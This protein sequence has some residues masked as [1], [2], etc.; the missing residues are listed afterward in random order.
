MRRDFLN[1]L[2]TV[3][4]FFETNWLVWEDTATQYLKE[5]KVRKQN[6]HNAAKKKYG[7]CLEWTTYLRH[8]TRVEW[9]HHQNSER[10]GGHQEDAA[11]RNSSL[12]GNLIE[13]MLLEGV[14]PVIA[15]DLE[16]FQK[17][18][19][20]TYLNNPQQKS[21]KETFTMDGDKNCGNWRRRRKTRWVTSSER[22]YSPDT[23]SSD[24]YEV[25]HDVGEVKAEL[26][27]LP[28]LTSTP[29]TEKF[30]WWLVGIFLHY[31]KT[32]S[33]WWYFGWIPDAN[34]QQWA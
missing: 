10:Q 22:T 18:Y 27:N 2:L 20:G 6:I 32:G 33:M 4:R 13:L 25:I 21:I 1:R 7:E 23:C 28:K 34:R 29:I 26:K 31:G 3:L 24:N 16:I 11:L 14:T 5:T 15:C 8:H 9:R 30:G 17:W 19:L 12:W